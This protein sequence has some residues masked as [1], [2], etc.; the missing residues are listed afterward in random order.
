MGGG[1]DISYT[2]SFAE[3]VSKSSIYLNGDTL[4]ISP[5]VSSVVLVSKFSKITYDPNMYNPL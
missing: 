4:N 2:S 5:P 1:D 3:D